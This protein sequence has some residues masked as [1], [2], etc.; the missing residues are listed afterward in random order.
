[1]DDPDDFDYLLKLCGDLEESAWYFGAELI[2]SPF[3][4]KHIHAADARFLSLEQEENDHQHHLALE[5]EH[6]PIEERDAKAVIISAAKA[7][8]AEIDI[9]L[10]SRRKVVEEREAII[11]RDSSHLQKAEHRLVLALS[12]LKRIREA[13]IAPLGLAS[14]SSA[15][16]TYTTG[17]PRYGAPSSP[18]GRRPAQLR[19]GSDRSIGPMQKHGDDELAPHTSTPIISSGV[20]P[21]QAMKSKAQFETH[22]GS[23]IA[24]LHSKIFQQQIKQRLMASLVLITRSP[25]SRPAS[26]TSTNP[27]SHDATMEDGFRI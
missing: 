20:N 18:I 26:A 4:P 21:V 13:E 17:A 12:E 5:V 25:K 2:A 6:Q 10:L 23:L 22:H 1:M 15:L 24:S 16:E 27:V 3:S 7:R 11:F 14:V 19:R 8:M 9:E